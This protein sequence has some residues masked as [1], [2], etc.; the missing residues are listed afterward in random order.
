MTNPIPPI[1]VINLPRRPDRRRRI[2]ANFLHSGIANVFY[3]SDWTDDI[4]GAHGPS[5]LDAY[6]GVALFPWEDPASTNP[7]FSRPMKWGEV[8]C[9]LAHFAAWQHM[10]DAGASEAVFLEDDAVFGVDFVSTLSAALEDARSYAFDLL[11]L[12]RQPQA[13]DRGVAGSLAIPGY[14]HCTYGY[15][16]SRSGVEKILAVEPLNGLIPVDELLPALYITHPRVDVASRY[17]PTLRAYA[18]DPSIVDQLPKDVAGSDTEDSL[19]IGA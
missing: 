12:G 15:V 18:C 11:Y 19:F 6:P 17:S 3:S 5:L 1:F 7:W 10:I 16:L 14:S 4:D 8:G 9:T 13:E 2:A